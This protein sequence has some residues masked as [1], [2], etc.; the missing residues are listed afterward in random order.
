MG[1][2]KRALVRFRISALL[3]GAEYWTAQGP[4][5]TMILWF[6]VG[7]TPCGCPATPCGRPLWNAPIIHSMCEG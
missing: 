5:P 1:K 7:T 4:S 6:V 2:N 3:L